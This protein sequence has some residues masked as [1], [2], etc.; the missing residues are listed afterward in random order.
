MRAETIKDEVQT[1]VIDYTALG[2]VEVTRKRIDRPL[3][4]VLRKEV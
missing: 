2:L 1:D 3:R 4:E